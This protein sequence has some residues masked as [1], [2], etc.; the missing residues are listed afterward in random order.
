M[1]DIVLEFKVRTT[2]FN[3]SMTSKKQIMLLYV[4]LSARETISISNS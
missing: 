1:D 4:C 3:T 2:S